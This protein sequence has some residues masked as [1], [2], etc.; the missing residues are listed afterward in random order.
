MVIDELFG[1]HDTTKFILI[2]AVWPSLYFKLSYSGKKISYSLV[3]ALFTNCL[4]CIMIQIAHKSTYESDK[5][6]RRELKL[7][8]KR[9]L[10]KFVSYVHQFLMLTFPI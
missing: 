3:S 10:R 7:K 2:R 9:T 6:A 5:V 4:I 8:T 1:L